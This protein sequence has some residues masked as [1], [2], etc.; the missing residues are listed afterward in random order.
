VRVEIVPGSRYAYSGGGYEIVQ[1]II[2]DVT[3]SPFEEALQ[4]LVLRPAGMADSL[5]AHRFRPPWY[6]GQQPGMTQMDVS[7]RA[8]GVL[9]PNWLQA[10]SGRHRRISPSS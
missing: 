1:A 9:F 5:F 6:Q 3:Q 10:G 2:Q 7:F 8:A 4:D